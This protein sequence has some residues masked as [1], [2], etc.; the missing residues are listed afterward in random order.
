MLGRIEP[1]LRGAGFAR[2]LGGGADGTSSFDSSSRGTR[3]ERGTSDS[4]SGGAGTGERGGGERTGIRWVLGGAS[5]DTGTE[6]AAGGCD[7]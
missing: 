2:G 6:A 7:E 3:G 5:A 1:M 4:M